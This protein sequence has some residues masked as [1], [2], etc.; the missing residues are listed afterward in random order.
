M[1]MRFFEDMPKVHPIKFG[2]ALSALGTSLMGA[3]SI[4]SVSG[5]H[6]DL[7]TYTVFT[8]F[9]TSAAGVFITTL[10][11]DS[12]GK[13]TQPEKTVDGNKPVDKSPSV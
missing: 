10:F 3:G 11:T 5:A 6:S 9:F 7:V 12:S 4:S 1:L 2:L 8:G 13:Q